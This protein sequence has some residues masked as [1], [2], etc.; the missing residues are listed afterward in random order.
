MLPKHLVTRFYDTLGFY[1]GTVSCLEQ[2]TLVLQGEA[3]T[4]KSF[5]LEAAINE[6]RDRLRDQ[7]VNAVDEHDYSYACS[8]TFMD[9]VAECEKCGDYIVN[10]VEAKYEKENDP[11]Q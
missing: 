6:C 11:G 4:D 9:L 8:T 10:V 7:N 3:D 5:R 1:S 2:M